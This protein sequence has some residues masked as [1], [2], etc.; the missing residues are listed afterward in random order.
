MSKNCF[1][2]VVYV[3]DGCIRRADIIVEDEYIAAIHDKEELS[4]SDVYASKATILLPGIIDD[5]VHSR[6][7]GLTRKGDLASETHAAAAGGVTSIMDMPN[8]VPQTTT[9]EAL[10]ERQQMGREHAFVNHAFFFGATNTN[11]HLL[12]QLDPTAVP[13]VKLFMGSSTGGMLVDHGEALQAIFEQSPLRIMAHCEDTAIINRNMQAAVE[14]YGEDPD[15]SQHPFIRSEEA[16]F[17]SSSLA[18]ELAEQTGARLHLAHITTARELQAFANRS[19]RITLEACLPHILFTDE[20]YAQ[21]G[22][23]IKCNPSIKTCADRD[24]LRRGLTDGSIT[25]VGTDHAPHL[26]EEKQGG[27]RKAVSGMPMVQ[28]SLV[29]MLQLAEEGVLTIPRVVELMCHAPAR[30]FGIEG[31]GFIREGMKADLTLVSH[32]PWTLAA[33]D[34]VSR[35]GWSPLEGRTFSWHVDRTYCNGSLIYDNGVFAS[36]N[37][38][39]QPLHFDDAV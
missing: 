24:A 20:D 27:A 39:A 26:L 9:L 30:L 22:S 12:H 28:F 14:K 38:H 21:L 13:G 11:A 34:V 3:S 36:D 35:C 25:L 18:V 32:K 19:D 8:V 16:C 6:E 37:Q 23:R 7:P 29:S 10:A 1:N 4:S 2:D 31:R 5:H 15:I 33:S 17:A